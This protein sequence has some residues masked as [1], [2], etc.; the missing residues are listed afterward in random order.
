[1]SLPLDGISQ[2]IEPS[3]VEPYFFILFIIFKPFST[4]LLKILTPLDVVVVT[5]ESNKQ[6]N[7]T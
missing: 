1:M 7:L 6:L 5:K 3:L 4:C 2:K